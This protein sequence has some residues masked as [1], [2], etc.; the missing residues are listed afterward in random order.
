MAM[1]TPMSFEE[2]ALLSRHHGHTAQ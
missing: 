1:V 2:A